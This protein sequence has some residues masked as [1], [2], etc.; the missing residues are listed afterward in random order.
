MRPKI[1]P[2]FLLSEFTRLLNSAAVVWVWVYEADTPTSFR[3]ASWD[4]TSR[5]ETQMI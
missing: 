3:L 5:G 2:G 1:W 4:V